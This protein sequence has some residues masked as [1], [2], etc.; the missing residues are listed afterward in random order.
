MKCAFCLL[1]GLGLL[2]GFSGC[3]SSPRP[4]ATQPQQSNAALL[5]AAEEHFKQGRLNA[6]EYD[7][8]AVVIADP[9]NNEAYYYLNLI[10]E[11]RY[12][13]RL[14]QE[15]L[16]RERDKLWYPTLPPREVH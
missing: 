5:R 13:H 10:A 4:T 3:R 8:R 11:S 7:L 9:R 6:A 12:Q 2:L 15:R 16:K 14:D 1:L